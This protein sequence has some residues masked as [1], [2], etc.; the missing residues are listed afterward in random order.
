M[1]N[2]HMV[3]F[4]LMVVG[5]LNW[6]LIGFFGFNLVGAL[7]GSYPMVARLVYVAVGLS[8]AYEL[9][10]HKGYCKFCGKK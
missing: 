4:L 3:T 9:A 10:I 5:A 8:A 6:G 7:F 2:L 1:K